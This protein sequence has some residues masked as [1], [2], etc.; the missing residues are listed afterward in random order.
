MTLT[1]LLILLAY[2]WLASDITWRGKK[3]KDAWTFKTK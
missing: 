2:L 1:L 3:I